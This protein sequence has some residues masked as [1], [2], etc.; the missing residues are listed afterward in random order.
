MKTKIAT[1]L[2]TKYANLGLSQTA[3]DGVAAILEKTITEE[4]AIESTIAEEYVAGLLKG[5]QRDFDKLRN[6]KAT[7]IKDLDDYKKAHP[8]PTP[9]PEPE[10]DDEISKK[11][12]ALEAKQLEYENKIRATE[13]QARRQAILESL[14]SKMKQDGCEN[15]FIRNM[16]LKGITIGENDT[17]DSM[18]E[19][20]K[21]EY[22]K[23]FK[24]AYGDGIVPPAGNGKPAEY[25]S[26]GYADEVARLRAEGKLPSENK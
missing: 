9:Q 22:N 7:A 23:N 15:D 26:G 4:S 11:I 17:A 3:F 19:T 21:A 13:A 25:K 14:S 2:K 5:L 20:Y 8:T 24:E 1:A 16:T 18:L 12:A 10:P 6:E